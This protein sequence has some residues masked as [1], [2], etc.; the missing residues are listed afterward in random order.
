[1]KVLILILIAIIF[2]AT[3]SQ[4]KTLHGR[5]KI[6]S[7]EHERAVRRV[8]ALAKENIDLQASIIYLGDSANLVK[9]ARRALNYGAPDERLIVVIPKKQ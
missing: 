5:A 6:L 4:L 9:E 7:E 8:D 1:M 2:V 3:V